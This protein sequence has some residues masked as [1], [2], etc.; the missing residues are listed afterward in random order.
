MKKSI[1]AIVLAIATLV[2]FIIPASAWTWEEDGKFEVPSYDVSIVDEGTIVID[3]KMETAYTDSQKI[4]SNEEHPYKRYGYEAIWGDIKASFF[5]Y[6]VVD[7]NGM[8]IYAEIEDSTMFDTLDTNAQSG[9]RFQIF[10]DWCPAEM[11]HPTS[12]KMYADYLLDGTKFEPSVDEYSIS[13]SY[14]SM[15]GS[16]GDQFLGNISYDYKDTMYG[17]W[18]F[19]P[20]QALGIEGD[21]AVDF[22]TGETSNGWKLETF[23][24]WR[25][26][27]QKEAIAAG[28][29]FHCG[30]GF[31]CSDDAD[32]DDMVSPGVEL[33]A[34]SK[35]DQRYEVGM[36]Y[37]N[38]YGSLADLRWGEYPEGYFNVAGGSDEAG[39]I[40][41][42]SDA[43]IA[44]VA[45]LAV[46]GA[47]VVLFSRK[48]KEDN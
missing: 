19:G 18:G 45:S 21:K 16:K 47:G 24:P 36:N 9:D 12:E 4:V 38:N 39:D 44:V 43:I 48:R 25:D 1:I 28:Q 23:I 3:G 11:M 8:Y 27:T 20:A 2:T 42:T 5:A 32:V 10:F 22:V 30:I 17:T 40:I 13:S 31:Q 35:Y 15:W 7:V 34:G 14:L 26:D 6:V 37:Y 29:Q 41:D 33:E 46:A